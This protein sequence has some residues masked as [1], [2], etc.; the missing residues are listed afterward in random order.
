MLPEPRLGDTDPT[1]PPTPAWFSAA[2]A[3]RAD[4]HEATVHGARVVA[5]GWGPPGPGVILVHGGAA[6]SHWWDHVAPALCQ[7]HRVVAVDLSG[8]GDSDHRPRYLL[9]TWADE[10]MALGRAAGIEGP[11]L[12][13]GHSMGGWVALATGAAY[14]SAVAG[15]IAIDAPRRGGAPGEAASATR[16]VFGPRRAYASHAE[17]L[18]RFRTVPEQPDSLPFILDHIART[19]LREHDGTWTWKFD[20][21]ASRRDRPPASAL[22]AQLTCPLAILRAENGIMSADIGASLRAETGRW[23]PVIEIPLAGHHIMLDQPLSL[24][25]ALRSLLSLWASE[26]DG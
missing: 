4:H 25:S 8:H 2:L 15:I 14:G 22:V 24:I 23:V 13:I 20:P 3:T 5:R 19:S 18:S 21:A 26:R 12:V 7:A 10:I 9:R 16:S 1:A 11:P 6:H 17:A